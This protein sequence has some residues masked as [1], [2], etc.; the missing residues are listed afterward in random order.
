MAKKNLLSSDIMDT[1][2]GLTKKAQE[3]ASKDRKKP[4]PFKKPAS[5]SLFLDLVIRDTEEV[6]TTYTRKSGKVIERKMI[7]QTEAIKKDYKSYLVARAEAEGISITKYIHGLI[8]ADMSK[9][10]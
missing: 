5:D 8:D 10:K 4:I 7:I 9:H 2:S 6:T 1:M 3:V